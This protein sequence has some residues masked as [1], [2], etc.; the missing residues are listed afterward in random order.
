M[1]NP[2]YIILHCSDVSYTAIPDQ[3]KSINQYH[4]DERGF[5]KSS[6]NFFVGY[7]YL[8]TGEKEYQCR[9]DTDEGAHCNQHENGLSLNFQSIG[10][11]VG[12]DGDIE[13]PT[14]TQYALLQKRVWA[15]QD[16]YGIPNE[17]VRFHRYYATSKTCP[18]S[19]ITSEWLAKL[20]IRPVVTSIPPKPVEMRCVAEEAEIKALKEQLSWFDRLVTLLMSSLKFPRQ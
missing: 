6:L 9:L 14:S 10:I 7:H 20:L 3:L 18:G 11:C 1:N 8:I 2:K 15:L 4:R 12:F 17:K 19:L 13:F 5:P 16:K